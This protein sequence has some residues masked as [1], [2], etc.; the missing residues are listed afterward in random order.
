MSTGK[1]KSQGN[2]L[3]RIY[4]DLNSSGKYK[5]V[6]ACDHNASLETGTGGGGSN[7]TTFNAV[8]SVAS[9]IVI[10]ATCDRKLNVIDMNVGKIAMSTTPADSMPHDRAI[11]TIAVPNPSIHTTSFIAPQAYTMFVTSATDNIIAFYDVRDPQ[12]CVG[13]YGAHVNRR[14]AVGCC[15]SPCLRYLA[16]G[17]EDKSIRI[18]DI[19]GGFRELCKIGN[20]HRDVTSSVAYSPLFPQLASCSY[21]GTVKFF[22]ENVT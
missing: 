18:V 14:E 16:T 3:K 7:I 11:H 6:Y 12:Y 8:N 20:V 17:S 4:N 22:T 15:F 13:R 1:S 10:S 9:P 2:D 19:R 21:D 5:C